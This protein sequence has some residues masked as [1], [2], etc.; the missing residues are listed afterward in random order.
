[1]VDGCGRAVINWAGMT[2]WFP[3]LIL[4]STVTFLSVAHRFHDYYTSGV[5]AAREVS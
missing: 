2:E 1:M 5:P 4:K 3:P